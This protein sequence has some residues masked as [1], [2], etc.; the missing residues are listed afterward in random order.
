V[1]IAFR[2]E[3]DV[4]LDEIWYDE[5]WCQ[6][7]IAEHWKEEEALREMVAEGLAEDWS[8]VLWEVFGKPPGDMRLGFL[9]AMRDVRLIP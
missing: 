4:V 2:L 7:L 6:E 1:K 9:S 5:Q 3:V 8:S